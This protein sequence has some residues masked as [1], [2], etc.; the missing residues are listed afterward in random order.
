MSIR[1]LSR[2]EQSISLVAMTCTTVSENYKHRYTN[3]TSWSLVA[4]E[5]LGANRLD[6]ARAVELV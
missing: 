3:R 6:L 1:V 2:D 5:H 4:L